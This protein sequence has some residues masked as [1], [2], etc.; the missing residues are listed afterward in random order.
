MGAQRK[1]RA[2]HSS[3][4]ASSLLR[5]IPSPSLIGTFAGPTSL[6]QAQVPATVSAIGRQVSPPATPP[7]ASVC[8]AKRSSSASEIHNGSSDHGPTDRSRRNASSTQ[9]SLASLPVT[10]TQVPSHSPIVVAPIWLVAT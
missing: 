10:L 1:D 6:I 7:E 3:S 5:A 2:F 4:R 9:V 8:Q